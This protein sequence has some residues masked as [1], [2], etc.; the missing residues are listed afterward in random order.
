MY[1]V[2]ITGLILLIGTSINYLYNFNG[3][4]YTVNNK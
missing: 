4:Y 2:I 3:N 1:L